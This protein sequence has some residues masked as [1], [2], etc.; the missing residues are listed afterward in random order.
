YIDNI[1]YDEYDIIL[2][3]SVLHHIPDLKDFLNK[4]SR[5]NRPNGFFIH[6][7]DPSADSI[8]SA[9]Y[10]ERQNTLESEKNKSIGVL[11][12]KLYRIKRGIIKFFQKD[13]L[14]EV[15]EQ[16]ISAGHIYKKL[17]PKEIWSVTDIHVE[18]NIYGDDG[19]I[20]IQNIKSMLPSYINIHQETYAF[21]GPLWYDLPSSLQS[22]E[23]R[24]QEA[25][26][27]FGR[28]IVGVWQKQ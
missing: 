23:L 24:L 17:T 28:N 4:I 16:L 8:N 9:I 1:P 15:N 26:D 12:N 21:F 13:Y 22:E 11:K 6:L 2:C 19:V 14:D 18:G 27:E 10:I 20:S 7:Q 5:I 25:K 3:S